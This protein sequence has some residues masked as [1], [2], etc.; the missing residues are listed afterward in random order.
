MTISNSFFIKLCCWEFRGNIENC[1]IRQVLVS[2]HLLLL[3]V[4]KSLQF[5]IVLL[6]SVKR[7]WVACWHFL[8]HKRHEIRINY[9]VLDKYLFPWFPVIVFDIFLSLSFDEFKPLDIAFVSLS[10]IDFTFFWTCNLSKARHRANSGTS[11]RVPLMIPCGELFIKTVYKCKLEGVWS[12]ADWDPLHA[13]LS[14][15]DRGWAGVKRLKVIWFG[16]DFDFK[17]LALLETNFSFSIRLR[18]A[19]SIESWKKD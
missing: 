1:L 10:F 4:N 14:V 16:L 8:L 2:S 11:V 12:D 19:K 17:I 18:S 15:L 5:V 6:K 7:W 13:T 3:S 9:R